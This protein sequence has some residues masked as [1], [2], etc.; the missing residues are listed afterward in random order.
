VAQLSYVLDALPII[1]PT[2][3]KKHWG[4]CRPLTPVKITHWCHPFSI[5]CHA[6]RN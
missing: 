6:L 1:E 2:L 4:E 3:S 5:H